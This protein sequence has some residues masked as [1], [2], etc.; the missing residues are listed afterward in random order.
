MNIVEGPF[1][2]ES[3]VVEEVNAVE[4][5]ELPAGQ[6]PQ[7]LQPPPQQPVLQPQQPFF[8][9][10]Y[11]QGAP[12]YNGYGASGYGSG[13]GGG[14]GGMYCFSGDTLVTTSNGHKIQIKDLTS[15]DWVLASNNTNVRFSWLLILLKRE[16]RLFFLP[17]IIG[18]IVCRKRKRF[19][20][21][22]NWRTTES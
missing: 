9:P 11:Q 22:F 2:A 15:D 8:Q 21:E 10:N 14:G 5:F 13:G 16:L 7:G 1:V 12:I 17:L 6:Q 4:G 19:S 18:Y 20:I 3:D